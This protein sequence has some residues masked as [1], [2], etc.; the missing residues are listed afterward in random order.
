MVNGLYMVSPGKIIWDTVPLKESLEDQEVKINVKLGG[1]CGSDTAVYKGKLA[2]ANYPVVPGHEV[3]GEVTEVGEKAKVKV[4]DRVVVQPN[5]YCGKC[6][7]CLE[8][9]TNVCPEKQSLGININGGFSET[10][11]VEDKYVIKVPEALVNE[12]AILVE[13]LAVIVHAFKK[14][15]LIKDASIAIIGCGT[16]GMLAIALATYLGAKVTAIDINNKKL[17]KVKKHYPDVHVALPKDVKEDYYDIVMEVAGT[18]ES[19]TQ[20]IDIV[21]PTGCVVSVG[22]PQLAEVSVVKIVRKEIT[23][24]GSI[25]YQAPQD[26]ETSINYLLDDNFRVESIISK[27][28][29]VKDY[30]EAYQ[31]A[32]SGDYRKIILDFE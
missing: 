2:H 12:R 1:I 18:A 3:L 13:P 23:I 24:K 4:G 30:E 29:N 9:K 6:E 32:V 27:V 15:R 10:L 22:F 20:C 7:Y 31:M 28:V 25:I 8:G 14:I 26:F 19:F 11:I 21:K 17:I 5:T 16:E